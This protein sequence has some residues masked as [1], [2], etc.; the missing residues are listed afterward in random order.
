MA[1]AVVLGVGFTA[2]TVVFSSTMSASQAASVGGQAL[3]SDAMIEQPESIAR[4][5]AQ[6]RKVDGVRLAEPLYHSS[7]R[8]RSPEA[9][10]SAT[11]D[12][13]PA[14]PAL[15]WFG[16]SRGSW[17]TGAGQV[18]VDASTAEQA[19]LTVGTEI[20]L[21]GWD[22]GRTATV[23]VS[24]ISD[25]AG[26]PLAAGNEQI[27]APAAVFAALDQTRYGSIAVLGTPG[28]SPDQLRDNLS[29]ALAAD[30]AVGSDATISTGAE[31][32]DR[33]V[34]GMTGKADA[35][36]ILL[37]GFAAIA[38]VVAAIVIGTTF[39]ILLTQRR[40]ELALLRCVGASTGQVRR[41]VLLEGVLL[42][43]GGSAIGVAVGIGVGALAARLTRL[44]AGGLSVNPPYLLGAFA[45]GVVVTVLAAAWPAARAMRVSP[46]A[47]LR[48]A[49]GALDEVAERRAGRI[50]VVLGSLATAAGAA[51]LGY[52]AYSGSL[53]IAMLGATVSA[54]GVLMLTRSVLPRVLG[55]LSPLAGTAGVPGRMAAANTRRNPGRS[56][57]TSAALLVG[58]ALI[59]TLQVGAASARATL[60]SELAGR[61]PVDVAVADSAGKPLPRSVIDGVAGSGVD[62]APVAGAAARLDRESPMGTREVL[63]LAPSAAALAVV[64]EPVTLADDTAVV[65]P[66]WTDSGIE[67]GSKLVLTVAGHTAT[68]TVAAGHLADAGGSTTVVIS[69][70]AMQRLAP[71]AATVALWAQLPESADSGEVTAALQKA[72]AAEPTVEVTGSAPE[73][74]STES[75]LGTMVTLATALLAVAVLIAIVGIG[76]TLG[77]SVLERTRESAL[78]RTLGL[79]RRQ[80]HRM[81]AVE[82]LLLA[83]VG[84]VVGIVLGLG[85]GIAGSMATVGT[86]GRNSVIAV[87]WGQLAIVLGVALL[88]GLIASVLPARR[89]GRVVPA[90]ALAQA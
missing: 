80:L 50:R 43:V 8:Y 3:R 9:K 10:G 33:Q 7:S 21:S 4:A 61:Y 16:L 78:L 54:L 72:T 55:L 24:G 70:R 26:S 14:D 19:N 25:A 53:A 88:A 89:A 65:P 11:L 76:N 82:A 44:D 48:P 37:L 39:T 73:R 59:V 68:F 83:A 18:V 31:L 51:A 47:A 27:F 6:A 36:G 52:G 62:P 13:L 20:T 38:M 58:V 66:W 42:G 34:R 57:G 15:R 81:V 56:S 63:V 46:L 29:T 60:D 69:Q 74:A 17:P 87:P 2:A 85:Y 5:L 35:L 64:N 79:Q 1:L 71:A 28:T 30:P 67:V 23:T 12:S 41:E 32:A 84:A 75:V 86:V 77:L 90:V 22:D 49:S 40:R 45:I